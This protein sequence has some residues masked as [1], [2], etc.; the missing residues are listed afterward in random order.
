MSYN[1]LQALWRQEMAQETYASVQVGALNL[2]PIL[3]TK[4]SESVGNYRRVIVEKVVIPVICSVLCTHREQ[5]AGSY[6]KQ[7]LLW[8]DHPISVASCAHEIFGF[9]QERFKAKLCGLDTTICALYQTF[10][11][12]DARRHKKFSIA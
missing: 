11:L 9:L 12:L 4:G 1:L 7:R 3:R 10:V 6:Q 8:L 2:V 5:A